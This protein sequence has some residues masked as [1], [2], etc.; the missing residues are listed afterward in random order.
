MVPI[1]D[2]ITKGLITQFQSRM[3]TGGSSLVVLQEHTLTGQDDWGDD[4]ESQ[5]VECWCGVFGRSSM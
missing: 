1:R 2:Q 3:K 5:E 4:D